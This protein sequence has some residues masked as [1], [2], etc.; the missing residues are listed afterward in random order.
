MFNIRTAQ[1]S[2]NMQAITGTV[3]PEA[4]P[5]KIVWEKIHFFPAGKLRRG[6]TVSR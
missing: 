5:E 3:A 4:S 2:V 6:A 1:P